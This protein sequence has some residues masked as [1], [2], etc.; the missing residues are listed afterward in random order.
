MSDLE[1]GYLQNG[2]QDT[3]RAVV[4]SLVGLGVR[5]VAHVALYSGCKDKVSYQSGH[6]CTAYARFVVLYSCG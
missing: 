1:W 2:H 6:L 4:T 5:E 3:E